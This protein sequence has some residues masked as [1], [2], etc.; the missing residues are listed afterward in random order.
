MLEYILLVNMLIFSQ[1]YYVKFPIVL[2][3]LII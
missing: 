2:M 1:N 3:E